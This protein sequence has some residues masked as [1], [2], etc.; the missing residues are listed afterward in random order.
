MA[1]KRKRSLR[2]LGF[3]PEKHQEQAERLA[4]KATDSF[5]QAVESAGQ[6]RC[7]LALEEYAYGREMAGAAMAESWAA[8]GG[9]RRMTG[10]DWPTW[11]KAI[12]AFKS[13]C[14]PSDL[15]GLGRRPTRRKR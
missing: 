8:S 15:R 9:K 10:D 4:A 5:K 1:A 13:N 14:F 12:A 2:G 3:A 7:S 6:K 11:D